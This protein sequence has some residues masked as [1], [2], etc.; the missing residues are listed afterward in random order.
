[1]RPDEVWRTAYD[2]GT[3]RKRY[4]KLFKGAK[5]DIL[6]IVRELPNGD[7]VWNIINRERAKMNALRIGDLIYR[8]E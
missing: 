3:L 5:Y 4:I 2:D 7:V 6:V 1:M 8:A